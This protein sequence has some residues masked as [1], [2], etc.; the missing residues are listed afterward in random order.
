MNRIFRIGTAVLLALCCTG[1]ASKQSTPDSLAES[2]QVTAQQADGLAVK[3]G[4]DVDAAYAE[5]IKTYFEAIDN[6]DFTGY[7]K[8]V[9]PPYQE[10]YAAF[11]KERYDSIEEFFHQE[12][13][14]HFDEDGYDSWKLT[15]IQLSA[16]PP[17]REDVDDFLERY[18]SAGVFDEEFAQKCKDDAA[19][20]HDIVFTLYALYE[21]DEEAVPVVTEGEL[22]VLKNADG[23]YLFG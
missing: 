14:K 6:D 5:C 19:E 13:S 22:F 11:I 7:Q 15:E 2:S 20:I 18:V 1:C 21:G 23:A 17:E 8:T 16:C 4:E 12:L 9:Y 10:V 3:A